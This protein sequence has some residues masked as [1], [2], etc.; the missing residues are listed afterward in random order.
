MQLTRNDGPHLIGTSWFRPDVDRPRRTR[1]GRYQSG[2]RDL[3]VQSIYAPERSL[4]HTSQG[5]MSNMTAQF[6]GRDF[7]PADS[8]PIVGRAPQGPW[9]RVC[10]R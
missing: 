8:K 9:R 1:F 3:L 2:L 4:S 5:S 6:P 7:V 10:S